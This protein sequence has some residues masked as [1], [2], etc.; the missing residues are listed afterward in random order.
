VVARVSEPPPPSVLASFGLRGVPVPLSGGRGTSWRVEHTVLKVADQTAEELEWQ[1]DVL[2]TLPLN[3]FRVAHVLRARDGS[4]LVQGWSATEFQGG[5]HEHRWAEIVR[6]GHRFHDALAGVARPSFLDRRSDPWAIGDRVAWDEQPL[7]ERPDPPLER[8][9]AARRPP[10]GRNQLIHGDLTGNVLFSAELP[11]AIIDLAPYW[12]PAAFASAIVVADALVWYD[13]DVSILAA[14]AHIDQF[15]QF[16]VRAL[17][18]RIVTD[19]LF[20]PG[21]PVPA[22]EED[23]YRDA[24]G[25]ACRLA[26]SGH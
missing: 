7:P 19:R 16:L 12:R 10:T 2:D 21:E 6:V 11:P 4:P 3:D 15:G 26:A 8:L 13:A 14:V 9:A 22:V 18:Y 20:R 5:R 24:V 17:I 1:A 25:L 23:P